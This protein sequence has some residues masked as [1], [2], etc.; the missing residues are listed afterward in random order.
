LQAPET[1]VGFDGLIRSRRDALLGIPNGI[2]VEVWNAATD[3]LLPAPYDAAHLDGKTEARRLLLETFGLPDDPEASRPVIAMV[4]RM[5]DQKGLDLIAAVAEDLPSLE[6]T[7]VIMG[8]GEPWYEEMWRSL[9][10]RYPDRMA[11]RIGF[12]EGL[13]HLIEAGADIFM[14]PSRHEPCGLNQMYSLRYGTVPVVRATGGARSS[15]RT[16]T[17]RET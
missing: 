11:V 2:D 8:E 16:T 9:A 5:V 6:A 10:R 12:D 13:S 3:P 14:M 1:A 7:F 15:R 4:S 17:Q